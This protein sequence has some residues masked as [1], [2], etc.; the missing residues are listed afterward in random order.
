MVRE[1]CGKEEQDSVTMTEVIGREQRP[2]RRE[3]RVAQPE[4]GHGRPAGPRGAGAETPG[5][6]GPIQELSF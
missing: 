2:G 3:R 6:L 5:W 4:N 1:Y